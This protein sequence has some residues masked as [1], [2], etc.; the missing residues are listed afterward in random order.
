MD[1]T[2][3]SDLEEWGSRR[4]H[5]QH[6]AMIAE[7]DDATR[8]QIQQLEATL[9]GGRKPRKVR[10][11]RTKPLREQAHDLVMKMYDGDFSFDECE[12][13]QVAIRDFDAGGDGLALERLL[14]C[15]ATE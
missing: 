8:Q 15:W 7:R 9:L 12:R 11:D 10:V 5:D 3:A 2:P 1:H 4:G 13:V 14:N 6:D